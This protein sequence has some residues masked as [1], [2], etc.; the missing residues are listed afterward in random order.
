M[1]KKVFLLM[2]FLL[3]V[4]A[5]RAQYIEVYIADNNGPY[6]NVR[7][8]IKGNIVSKIP[9]DE[10]IMLY[11]ESP[12][13]G[14]WRICDDEY[15]NPDGD[16]FGL[17]GSRKGYWIHSSVIGVSTRNYGGEKLCLMDRP[18]AK[19][20]VVYTFTEEI[21]LHPVDIMGDWVKVKTADG[22]HVG[23]ILGEWLCGNS[24]TNCC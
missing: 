15:W 7:D 5:V 6:T 1:K 10:N 18:S 24:V 16:T 4:V 8:G 22:K 3:A 17:T 13:N 2:A 23:W 20:K 19:S 11:V 21:L 14:W 12:K 9:V